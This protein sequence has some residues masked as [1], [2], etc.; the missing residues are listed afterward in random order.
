M[1]AATLTAKGQVVIPA[2]IRERYGLVPGTRVEFVD[3]GAG[4]RL[5]VHRRARTTEPVAGYGMIRIPP[6]A[7]R[8][9]ADF[10]VAQALARTR[11]RP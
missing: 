5:V 7:T 9:L 3:D 10:D 2:E 11:R 8:R 1:P 4:I 6:R